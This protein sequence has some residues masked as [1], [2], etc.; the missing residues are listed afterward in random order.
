MVRVWALE[1]HS[2]PFAILSC[3][4]P[5]GST[6]GL[7]F[8]WKG[9][10]KRDLPDIQT[11]SLHT[12]VSPDKRSCFHVLKGCSECHEVWVE[13]RRKLLLE[14]LTFL[15]SFLCNILCGKGSLS[16][17]KVLEIRLSMSTESINWRNMAKNVEF[18][19]SD[20]GLISIIG[21][22]QLVSGGDVHCDALLFGTKEYR[23]EWASYCS[24]W[25]PYLSYC[26]A[27]DRSR[28]GMT[29]NIQSP[30]QRDST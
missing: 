5:R 24:G 28:V 11:I 7:I 15:Q 19:C 1:L 4:D 26:D 29:F 10:R 22:A 27:T 23:M 21:R 13:K 16:D 2:L 17:L 6:E 18:Q 9:P 30:A 12:S 8:Y 3:W 25:Y 14:S 20:S